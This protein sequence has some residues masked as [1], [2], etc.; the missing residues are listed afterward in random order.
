[1]Q[2]FGQVDPPQNQPEEGEKK[3]IIQN[4]QDS[5]AILLNDSLND[6]I[7]ILDPEPQSPISAQ[8]K[9]KAEDSIL[10][11]AV[12]QKA[13]LFH[14]AEVTYGDLI[15]KANYIEINMATNEVYAEGV[16]DTNGVV[17]GKPEFT[18]AGQTYK[19][20][21]MAYNFNSGK[22]KTWEARTEQNE[23]FIHGEEIKRAND[24]VIFVSHGKFT[25]CSLEHP[26]FYVQAKKLKVI[27]DQKIITGPANMVIADVPTP[28][29]VPF[30]FF[31]DSENRKNGIIFPEPDLSTTMGFNLRNGGY[32]FSG[33]EFYDVQL[34]GDI[35]TNGS[36]SLRLIPEYKVKYRFNGRFNL[37]YASM[38]SGD[39][40]ASDFVNATSYGIQWRHSQD[41][42][43]NPNSN[44]NANVNFGSS[45]RFTNDL[46]SG[47]NDYLSSNF[48]SNISY[49]RQFK[50]FGLASSLSL[51]TNLSQNIDKND[52]K[53]NSISLSLPRGNYSLSRFFPFARK[54]M[55]GKQAWYEKIGVALN[56]SFDN[57][58]TMGDTV[59]GTP[60]MWDTFQNGIQHSIP[61]SMNLK[62]LK[63]TNLEPNANFRETWYSNS[64]RET[65]Y[66]EN[67]SVA[68]DTLSG[69]TRYGSVS[70]GASYSFRL[71]GIYALKN[72][73]R[74]KKFRHTLSPRVSANLTP[75]I[76]ASKH[77]RTYTDTLGNEIKYSTI[78][79]IYGAP[80]QNRSGRIGFNLDNVLE[81]KYTPRNDTIGEDKNVAIFQGFNFSTSYD[82]Y[83]DSLNWSDLSV[84]FRSALGNK[85]DFR[86]RSTFS[87]YYY[88]E[89][90]NRVIDDTYLNQTGS[91]LRFKSIQ[92]TL[93]SRLTSQ[94]FKP[95][96]NVEEA[97]ENATP[98]QL[99]YIENNPEAFVDFNIPWSLN[100]T[101]SYA[102]T[103][104]GTP[105][106]RHSIQFIGDFSLTENMKIAGRSGYDFEREELIQTSFSIMRDLHCWQ[107]SLDITPFGPRQSYTFS[108]HPK[109]GILS[110]L[111][112][113]RKRNWDENF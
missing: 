32:Y 16:E 46:N 69:F 80:S 71:Y 59:F 44:F 23:G 4:N 64:F 103:V 67:D 65:Y 61:V 111:K 82:I 21:K 22:G 62:V 6:S 93:N 68:I 77:F 50:T 30:G 47:V 104:E 83:A 51:Q 36:Y 60:E 11:D 91:I 20:G 29:W 34:L 10:F 74:V 81:M 17:Q 113:Q 25:T 76:N 19:A 98:E 89:D 28:L 35:Y 102:I 26:H 110:D 14:E 57:R 108:I 85:L 41:P 55:V 49:S 90:A 12:N 70:A 100:T 96:E 5:L 73:G 31:P 97:K 52:S 8:I 107:M 92:I 40:D 88:S 56:S 86:I 53:K 13:F 87:P 27:P 84:D 95:N 18:Q 94:G 54:E 78:S 15:L 75:A 105:T 99:D 72:P 9:Y 1:M 7:P 112:L 37:N 2:V 39:P 42:K 66:P 43:A 48:N 109:P 58:A 33:N 106:I 24:S 38:K 45:N 79:G 3:F 101:Y 63:Y